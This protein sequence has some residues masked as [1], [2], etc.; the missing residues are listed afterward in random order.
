M[1]EEFDLLVIGTGMAG[2]AAANK[3]GSHG[4]RVGIVDA[5]PYGGTC[6]LR[7]C[8]PKKILRRGAEVIE[9]ARLMRGK[10]VDDAGLAINWSDLMRHKRGYTDEAPKRMEDEL[11]RNGVSTLHGTARFVT[12]SSLDV[13]GTTYEAKRFLIAAGARPR[14]LDFPGSR[15]PDRQ[16]RV[17]GSR[18]SAQSN[19]V[20]RRR[21][22]LLRVRPHRCPCRGCRVI[23]DHGERALDEF[24]P[25]LVELLISRGA[26]V[27]IAV[28]RDTEVVAVERIGSEYRSASS[29]PA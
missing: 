18:H 11:S 13:D 16:H 26:Q 1:T 8:D 28:Q 2:S 23:I 14:P 29:G 12:P 19:R 25:D 21:V 10:G 22:H 3:C 15:V 4:W 7:G 5:L 9:S 27:G 20:R 6:A 17:L 24:D